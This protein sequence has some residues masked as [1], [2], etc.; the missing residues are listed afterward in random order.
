M[1]VLGLLAGIFANGEP[2]HRRLE[3]LWSEKRYVGAQPGLGTAAGD[4]LLSVPD[5]FLCLHCAARD[6]RVSV[7]RPAFGL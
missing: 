5:A 1:D 7:F 3:E 6:W 2:V 4:R